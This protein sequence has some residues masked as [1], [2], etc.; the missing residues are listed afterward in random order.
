Y[1]Q[2]R[3]IIPKDPGHV[4]RFFI[5]YLLYSTYYREIYFSYVYIILDQSEL[6]KV[7]Q[8]QFEETDVVIRNYTLQSSSKSLYSVDDHNIQHSMKIEKLKDHLSGL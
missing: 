1:M 4:I 2:S 3:Q 6:L 7:L 8:R 5:L